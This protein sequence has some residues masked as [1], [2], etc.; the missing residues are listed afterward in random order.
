MAINLQFCEIISREHFDVTF[1]SSM[2]Q[3]KK[4]F[5]HVAAYCLGRLTL[6]STIYLVK[7]KWTLLYHLFS[8]KKQLQLICVFALV[9]K[10]TRL[11]MMTGDF[12]VDYDS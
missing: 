1:N 9:G 7:I 2:K 5:V 8:I 4:N 10:S 11:E 6:V 3:G 12:C